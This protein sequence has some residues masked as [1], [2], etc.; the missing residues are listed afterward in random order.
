MSRRARAF[1][2]KTNEG[3]F[4]AS[5]QTFRSIRPNFS[6]KSTNMLLR[7]ACRPQFDALGA[8]R[9]V[10]TPQPMR[11]GKCAALLLVGNINQPSPDR[12]LRLSLLAQSGSSFVAV[13]IYSQGAYTRS[14]STCEIQRRKGLRTM[15]RPDLVEGLE[16]V[17]IWNTRQHARET[18]RA[19]F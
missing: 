1:R 17:P 12:P 2:N 15:P 14:F 5:R 19:N 10:E 6:R 3:C 13:S 18:Y 8:V 11:R 9:C 16:R 7:I 4:G